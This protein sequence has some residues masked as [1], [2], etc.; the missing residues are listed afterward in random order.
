VP[1]TPAPHMAGIAPEQER[2]E[3]MAEQINVETPVT[4]TPVAIEKIQALLIEKNM[5]DH[6]LRVFVGGGG[7]S[8]LQYGMAF[9]PNPQETDTITDIDGVR[10]IIDPVSL[11]YLR[12]AQIDYVE[13]LMGGGFSI[14]NPNAVSTCG[15]GHSFRTDN[16]QGAAGHQHGGGC[17]CG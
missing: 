16:E 15:C 9:E 13:N 3:L 11:D 7:C 6:G 4:V 8:G 12:G 17:N 5:Q 10:I 1:Q 14:E 2:G